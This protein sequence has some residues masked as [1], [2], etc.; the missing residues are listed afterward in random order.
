[1]WRHVRKISIPSRFTGEEDQCVPRGTK[2]KSGTTG[3]TEVANA[4]K[5]N[6]HDGLALKSPGVKPEGERGI[7]EKKTEG[8][9]RKK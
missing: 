1:V 8:E 5:N 7:E 6:G 3:G 9:G 4:R 2:W